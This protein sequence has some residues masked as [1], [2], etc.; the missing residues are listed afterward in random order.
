M[1]LP[2]VQGTGSCLRDVQA[3]DLLAPYRLKA[4]PGALWHAFRLH[5]QAAFLLSPSQELVQSVFNHH[6]NGGEAPVLQ[7]LVAAEE[8]K[9]SDKEEPKPKAK[10]PVKSKP[11]E[12]PEEAAKENDSSQQ[13]NDSQAEAEEKPSKT[14]KK[15]KA[16]ARARAPLLACAPPLPRAPAKPARAV[17]HVGGRL[18]TSR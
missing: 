13:E 18:T 9:A 14:S 11:K 5:P 16:S 6:V 10:S 4:G 12:Q 8:T 3:L 1:G 17:P 15:K 2:Q 7:P